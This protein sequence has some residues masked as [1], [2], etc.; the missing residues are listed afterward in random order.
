MAWSPDEELVVMVTGM[1]LFF[2]AF[3]IWKKPLGYR[4]RG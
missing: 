4:T 1:I 3:S 2:F